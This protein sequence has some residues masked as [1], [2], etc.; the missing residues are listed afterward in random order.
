MD[1]AVQV[2]RPVCRAVLHIDRSVRLNLRQLL[3]IN[4]ISQVRA[5]QNRDIHICKETVQLPAYPSPDIGR[6][7]AI[8]R[9]GP[10]FFQFRRREMIGSHI[11][12]QAH[13]VHIQSSVQSQIGTVY[14]INAK[15]VEFYIIVIHH[16]GRFT[17][18][19]LDIIRLVGSVHIQRQ[20]FRGDIQ[21]PG[22]AVH[23][24]LCPDQTIQADVIHL[25]DTADQF[26]RDIVQSDLR[27]NRLFIQFR[28]RNLYVHRAVAKRQFLVNEAVQR[29]LACSAQFASL[30]FQIEA[31]RSVGADVAH[32]HHP[33]GDIGMGGE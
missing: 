14:A 6:Q 15:I 23:A 24:R 4:R 17:Q 13:L 8:D 18:T 20:H 30:A 1:D 12:I 11:D 16:N 3:F 26:E 22:Q 9:N 25:Y 28:G 5:G 10:A 27:P 7:L 32:A 29:Q 33:L 31:Q 21:I 19:H 2:E